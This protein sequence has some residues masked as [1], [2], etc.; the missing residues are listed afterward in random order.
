M[1]TDVAEGAEELGCHLGLGLFAN[2]ALEREGGV[3][4][5]KSLAHR[6]W[7]WRDGEKGV[8]GR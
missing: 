7:G 3:G 8:P 1:G 4:R 2:L 5:G 6:R